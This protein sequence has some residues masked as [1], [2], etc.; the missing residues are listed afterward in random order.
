MTKDELAAMDR[1]ATQELL[2]DE[3]HYFADT[4]CDLASCSHGETA[5]FNHQGDGPFIAALWNGYRAGRIAVIDDEA[6]PVARA[7]TAEA[8]VE[9]LKERLEQAAHN[10]EVGAQLY[11]CPGLEEAG[12]LA[13][14]V[15]KGSNNG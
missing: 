1:A 8:W 2:A 9:V 3:G 15:L 13:R 4:L 6:V 12:K 11:E 14:Q 7:T 5:H 10:L